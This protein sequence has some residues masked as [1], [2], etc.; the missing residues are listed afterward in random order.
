MGDIFVMWKNSIE[1]FHNFLYHLNNSGTF[2]K[3]TDETDVSG[4]L[5]FLDVVVMKKKGSLKIALHRKPTHTGRYL[6][7][8]SNQSTG[9]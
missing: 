9:V 3:F 7:Y 6:R 8:N 5:P 1:A 2:I 4:H